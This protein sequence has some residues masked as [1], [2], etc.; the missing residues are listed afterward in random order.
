V[1]LDEFTLKK[2]ADITHAEYFRAGNQQEL[3]DV[4]K[5]LTKT[6]IMERKETELTGVCAG[7][8]ALLVVIAA[9]LSLMWTNRLV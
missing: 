2:V 1:R 5:N 6:L 7:L 4:Y 3:N 9:M 8:A